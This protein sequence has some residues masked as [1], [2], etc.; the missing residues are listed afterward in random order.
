MIFINLVHENE[1][2]IICHKVRGFSPQVNKTFF[3]KCSEEIVCDSRVNTTG[4]I[5]NKSAQIKPK[6]SVEDFDT[7][8]KHLSNRKESAEMHGLTKAKPIEYVTNK[9]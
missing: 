3:N 8:R 5:F 9:T 7:S 2:K 4:P 6:I 1:V